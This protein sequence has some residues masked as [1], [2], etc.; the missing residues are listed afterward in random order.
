MKTTNTSQIMKLTSRGKKFMRVIGS[1]GYTVKS[2]LKWNMVSETCQVGALVEYYGVSG[3]FVVPRYRD[4]MTSSDVP[5]ER[6]GSVNISHFEVSPDGTTMAVA[7]ACPEP[8][9]IVR[10][11][12]TGNVLHRFEDHD[13][14][15]AGI[16]ISHDNKYMMS[17]GDTRDRKVI[18]F[19]LV[20][21][22]IVANTILGTTQVINGVISG[23]FVLDVK[24]RPTTKYMFVTCG[25]NHVN[26]WEF[27]PDTRQLDWRS[28][29]GKHVREFTCVLYIQGLLLIGTTT[30]DIITV[31]SLTASPNPTPIAGSGGICTISS[32]HGDLV[33]AGAMD[34]SVTVFRLERSVLVFLQ[35][36]FL[37]KNSP[38]NSISIKTIDGTLHVL[39]GN[40]SGSEFIITMDA[41]R[42]SGAKIDLIRQVPYSPV[43]EILFH[44]KSHRILVASSDIHNSFDYGKTW[45]KFYSSSNV[46]AACCSIN[47]NLV[48]VGH[49]GKLVGID[50]KTGG[51]LWNIPFEQNPARTDL[52]SK[53]H[54]LVGSEHGD[55]CLYDLRSKQMKSRSKDCSSNITGVKFFSGEEFCIASGGRSL[56]TYDLT[57]GKRITHHRERN[58]G[59]NGFSL[60]Q[61]QATVVS[62]GAEKIVS[63]WDLRVHESINTVHSD[64]ELTAVALSEPR[65]AFG[66]VAGSVCLWDCRKNGWLVA[67]I[68][69]SIGPRINT[70]KWINANQIVS[71]GNDNC[72]TIHD[73]FVD[74]TLTNRD[75]DHLVAPV[76]NKLDLSAC[77]V[78]T[79]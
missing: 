16:A 26:V 3:N 70:V 30:G 62:I 40:A 19:D 59:I 74:E 33:F 28:A 60:F 77:I 56:V 44:E 29:V 50:S 51:F 73:P 42:T 32:N 4:H 47:S 52:S 75:T 2:S 49:E 54:L 66:S 76:L 24:N 18:I 38:I 48:V 27:D 68:T 13:Q 53:H 55:V 57:S 78:N 46:R 17:V 8:N 21:G 61:D 1:N 63:F 58:L 31:K 14:G 36:L 65:I 72:I 34:G 5:L 45:S 11:L 43:N 20:T 41:S 10:S 69:T 25:L 37:E 67:P 39:I 35:K 6:S 15:I 7:H 79:D 23:G 71:G 9:I 12:I 64:I 22:D